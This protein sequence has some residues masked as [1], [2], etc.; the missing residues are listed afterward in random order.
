MQAIQ[1]QNTYYLKG[2]FATKWSKRKLSLYKEKIDMARPAEHGVYL[3][4]LGIMPFN[5]FV[6]LFVS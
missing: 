1:N 5:V 2:T 6:C 3:I 4:C